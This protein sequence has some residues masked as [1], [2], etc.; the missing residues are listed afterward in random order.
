MLSQAV[1]TGAKISFLCSKSVFFA[2]SNILYSLSSAGYLSAM[3][4]SHSSG[5]MCILP[6]SSVIFLPIA[7][8]IA[9]FVSKS[10]LSNASLAPLTKSKAFSVS[11]NQS[12][13]LVSYES[14][15]SL[16]FA[17]SV[18]SCSLFGLYS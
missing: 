4:T 10:P 14:I 18:S 5:S 3:G 2:G 13:I 6:S 16:I 9:L 8:K 7:A 11:S 17:L 12:S 15:F 1:R